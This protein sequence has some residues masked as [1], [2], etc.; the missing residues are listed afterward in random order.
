MSRLV[1]AVVGESWN[2]S[3]DVEWSIS[4]TCVSPFKKEKERRPGM[5]A[6]IYKP[7]SWKAEV[8]ESL[9]EAFPRQKA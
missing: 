2:Q 4:L 7:S 1:P 6:H 5:V 8:G 9:C 3:E